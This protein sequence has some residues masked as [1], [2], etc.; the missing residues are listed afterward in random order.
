MVVMPAHS[1]FLSIILLWEPLE[2]GSQPYIKLEHIFLAHMFLWHLL[3]PRSHVPRGLRV[4]CDTDAMLGHDELADLEL[5]I[6]D[7]ASRYP[8]V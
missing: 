2:Q 1:T 4:V 6:C 8:G 5:G 3:L 7:G